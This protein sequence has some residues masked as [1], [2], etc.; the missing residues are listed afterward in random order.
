[1]IPSKSFSLI[2]DNGLHIADGHIE[3]ACIYSAAFDPARRW[4]DVPDMMPDE[5]LLSKNHEFQLFGVSRFRPHSTFAYP[6]TP[7]IH[8]PPVRISVRAFAIW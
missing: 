7:E 4:Y 1:L 2:G 8:P 3:E 6:M 5:A